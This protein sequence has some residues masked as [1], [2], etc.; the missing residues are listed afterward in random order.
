MF[1]P[2]YINI[3]PDCPGC[4]KIG[5]ASMGSTR[6]GHSLSCCSDACGFAV[7]ARINQN[8]GTQEYK[9][10]ANARMK[11]VQRARALKYKGINVV[12]QVIIKD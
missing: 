12:G 6:W 1:E 7:A 4:G 9:Q 3:N 5:A 10:A 2:T 8:T 11:A